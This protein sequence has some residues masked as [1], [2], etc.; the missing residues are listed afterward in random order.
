HLLSI[1]IILTQGISIEEKLWIIGLMLHRSEDSLSNQQFLA[2]INSL[3]NNGE[4][5]NAFL[6]IPYLDKLQWWAL[7][8][9]TQLQSLSSQRKNRR[10]RVIINYCLQK[11]TELFSD[12]GDITPLAKIHD[13]W[14]QKV[15]PFLNA[16]PHIMQNY[17]VYYVYHHNFPFDPDITP[18]QCYQLLIADCFLL[19]S[20]L[21]LIAMANPLTLQDV[22]D[23][24]YSYHCI[25]MHNKEFEKAI[26]IGLSQHGC[27]NDISLY[28][29]LNT[30]P[31]K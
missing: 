6:Q 17:L 18:Q 5:H 23:L 20:Y 25:R 15:E 9:L 1:E 3:I 13:V 2:Q 19:R 16:H 12:D 31:P 8:Q 22:T 7:H 27:N 28:A 26:A 14:H 11:I 4:L 30:S 29:L 21:C 10:G 24:F